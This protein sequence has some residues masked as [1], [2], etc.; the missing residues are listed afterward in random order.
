MNRYDLRTVPKFWQF[1]NYGGFPVEN[2]DFSL[3]NGD[4]PSSNHQ[5]SLQMLPFSCCKIEVL[6]RSIPQVVHLSVD[7]Q[8][9]VPPRSFLDVLDPEI[10]S[11][12]I[13]K[14]IQNPSLCCKK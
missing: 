14:R 12:E 7:S 1:P 13:P 6:T 4:V 3:K 9:Y 2:G 8:V 11:P 10:N 5:F